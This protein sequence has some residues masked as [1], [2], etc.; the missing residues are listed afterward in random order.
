MM[1]LCLLC[2]VRAAAAQTPPVRTPPADSPSRP[3]FLLIL[4]DDQVHPDFGGF[5]YMPVLREQLLPDGVTFR[6]SFATSP[7]CTPMRA[8]LLTG[9]YPR[10]HGTEA[11]GPPLGGAPEFR[12]AGADQE[13]IACWLQRAGYVTGL[14]GKYM[15]NY[16][17]GE[18]TAGK[19]GGYYVPPCWTRWRAMA[20]PEAY[21]G[22]RGEDYEIVAWDASSAAPVC[23]DH[24]PPGGR[25][26]KNALR[27]ECSRDEDCPAKGRGDAV[28]LGPGVPGVRQHVSCG[29]CSITARIGC[30]DD[31]ACTDGETCRI[32]CVPT[33]VYRGGLPESGVPVSDATYATDLLGAW[34]R[35][36]ITEAIRRKRPFFAVYSPYAGHVGA[37]VFADPSARHFGRLDG[38]AP[39][40]PPS[41][42][43][44][45]VSDKPRY[46]RSAGNVIHESL[47]PFQRRRSFEALMAV[48]EQIAA[49]LEHLSSLGVRQ[50]TVIAY[51]S[52]NGVCY[53]EHRL[54]GMKKEA[55][56]ECAIK[57]PIVLSYPR[58]TAAKRRT[59]ENEI[60]IL[61]DI[62]VTFADLAS[63]TIPVPVDGMSLAP[64]LRGGSP[65][66][67]RRDV[68][69]QRWAWNRGSSVNYESNPH[70]G[71]KLRL[72]Y[73]DRYLF[74]GRPSMLFEFDTGDGVAAGSVP[75]RVGRTPEGTFEVLRRVIMNR[76]PASTVVHHSQGPT[77][78]LD[79]VSASG[80]PPDGFYFWEEVDAGD[81]FM[82]GYPVPDFYG[83]RDARGYTYVEYN[84]GERELYDLTTDPHQLD[85]V[86]GKPGYAGIQS[87]LAARLV[88]ILRAVPRRTDRHL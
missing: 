23:S 30:N 86:Y 6:Q 34:V 53:G 80:A 61:E 43:E 79:V 65:Q 21:G 13:T 68:L 38:I 81:A 19:E 46:V 76:V 37:G 74:R 14:F 52:D 7:V 57:V 9:A 12:R 69:L 87:E 82:P 40:Q 29:H 48:D 83:I 32:D 66:R 84:N 73:G 70:D 24:C 42:A 63:V 62:P 85:N 45:D 56:Y 16:S 50:D 33:R 60:A 75:V 5:D 54:F 28:C 25:R 49:L 27:R 20:S 47:T 59:I 35:E 22:E 31:S 51:A 4:T 2:F 72:F 58:L 55:P 88:E 3:N 41:F 78:R 77:R 36:F 10:R 67:W 39:W 44:S 1:A 17:E 15:N 71:D 11:V 8:S 18:R 26:C 64:W